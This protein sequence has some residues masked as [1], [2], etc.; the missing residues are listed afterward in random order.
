MG[1]STTESVNGTLEVYTPP[2]VLCDRCGVRAQASLWYGGVVFSGVCGPCAPCA[3]LPHLN[4][5]KI[6][7]RAR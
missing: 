4:N 1:K 6:L 2:V 7:G 3:G 5:P